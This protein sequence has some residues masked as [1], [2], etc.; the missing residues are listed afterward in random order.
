MM[1]KYVIGFIF[2][3]LKLMMPTMFTIEAIYIFI[4]QMGDFPILKLT[5]KQYTNIMHV[6]S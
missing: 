3:G 4:F 6:D 2:E 5:F 1:Q